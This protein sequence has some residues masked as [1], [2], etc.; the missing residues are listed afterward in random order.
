YKVTGVQTCALPISVFVGDVPEG[1]GEPARRLAGRDHR[2]RP[3][4]GSAGEIQG[5]TLQPVRSAARPADS[6]AGQVFQADRRVLADQPG[7]SEDRCVGKGWVS[8]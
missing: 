5:R 8:W 3:V 2:D 4:A 7:R 1:D 6:D